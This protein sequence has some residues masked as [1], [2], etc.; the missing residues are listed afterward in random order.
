MVCVIFE[1]RTADMEESFSVED[2]P[3]LSHKDPKR[4]KPKWW[5]LQHMVE[6][7]EWWERR[8]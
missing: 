8:K 5:T 2:S 4:K 3:W 7:D 1:A 6:W